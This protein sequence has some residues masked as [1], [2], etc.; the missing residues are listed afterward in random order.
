MAG[1][2]NRRDFLKTLF[3][4]FGGILALRFSW[5]NVI[6]NNKAIK[7]HPPKEAKYYRQAD[8]LAG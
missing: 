2:M 4:F 5:P 3:A 8:H 1:T 6:G 7:K